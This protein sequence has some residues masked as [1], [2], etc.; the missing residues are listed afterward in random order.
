MSRT[1]RWTALLG[2]GLGC[3]AIAVTVGM[4]PLRTG[5]EAT[6]N[7]QS[8]PTRQD[9]PAAVDYP[10]RGEKIDG[11]SLV[12]PRRAVGEEAIASVRRAGADWIAVVPYAFVRRGSTE[13]LFDRGRQF[14]GERTEGVA[15]TIELARRRGLRVML[16]PHVWVA[17]QGWAGE[18]E[19]STEEGWRTF[20]ESYARYILH[21]ARLA[22]SLE[23]EIFCL[24][25][26]MDRVVLARPAYWRELAARVRAVF[27]GEITYAANWDGFARIPIWDA[28]DYVGV[29]A[30]FPLSEAPTPAVS[31]LERRWIPHLRAVE[32]LHRYTGKPVLFTE[33][34][35]R[36]I[37]GAAGEQWELPDERSG[38]GVVNLAAQANAY[39]ALFRAWWPRSWFAGGFLWKWYPE[40]A[41]RAGGRRDARTDGDD[42]GI[43][44]RIGPRTGYTPQGK[45]PAEAVIRRWYG[46]DPPDGGTP[47]TG[48]GSA[49]K[50]FPAEARTGTP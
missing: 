44:R 4:P 41:S 36:S 5:N 8:E 3:G 47:G 7:L 17:G 20:E 26:E 16:K 46:P 32:N 21:F 18:F 50:R 23:V 25:T 42:D 35:Y 9:A 1:R 34:G 27:P 29:D 19:P 45:P 48:A 40:A 2:L 37:D 43:R 33:F 13:V 49:P 6:P 15:A 14:W 12:A 24:G 10:R 30:Y 38:A 31:E 11:V 28:L 22:G 39:E